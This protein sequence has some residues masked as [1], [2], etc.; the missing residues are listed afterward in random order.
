MKKSNLFPLNTVA[1]IL[2]KRNMFLQAN[3]HLS[4]S[5]CDTLFF[6]NENRSQLLPVL[7][8]SMIEITVTQGIPYEKTL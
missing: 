3:F 1:N 2:N 6:D 4:G 8:D 7:Y 5:N